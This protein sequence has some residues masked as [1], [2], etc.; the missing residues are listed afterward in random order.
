MLVSSE[1]R[2]S[3]WMDASS[4]ER[5]A[6]RAKYVCT[7]I[8]E[9]LENI[10][11]PLFAFIYDFSLLCFSSSRSQKTKKDRIK[12]HKKLMVSYKINVI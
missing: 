4:G 9:K 5:R 10:P 2:F 8:M 3:G 12:T 7:I 6:D 1:M 11:F